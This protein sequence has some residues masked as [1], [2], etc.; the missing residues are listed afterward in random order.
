MILAALPALAA[1]S[2]QDQV[3]LDANGLPQWTIAVWNDF[4]VQLELADRAALEALLAAVPVASFDREQ[5]APLDRDPKSE[6]LVFRPRVTEA[7]FAALEAAGYAPRRLRDFDR[8]GRE[9]AERVWLEMSQNKDEPVLTAPYNYYPTH[10]QVGTI[11]ATIETNFPAI[12]RDFQWGTSI[13]GRALW[14]LVIS[15]NVNSSEAEPEVR[16]S[17]SMHGDEVTGQIMLLNFA[18]YLTENY[19]VPGRE[20]V[21]N[22]VDNYEIH[23]MPMHNPDG[24]VLNQRGNANGVDL[25]RNFPEPAGD[26]LVQ[27]TENLA[28]MSY[29]HSH[30]FVMSSNYHGGALVVNYLWDYTYTLAPDDAACI[31]MSLEYSTYN[32]PMYNGSFPQGITNGA[33]WYVALGTLQDWSYDQTGCI[34]ATI[35]VSN[36]KWPSASLLPTFWNENRES[37]MHYVK[38]ARYGVNGVVTGSDTGQ[39]LDATVTVTGNSKV[40]HTDPSHGDYYKLLA[41]G[42]YQLTFSAYGY[43]TRTISNV[44]T[45]W[46]TPTVLNVALDPIATGAIAGHVMQTGG[47]PVAAQVKA[48]THPLNELIDTVTANAAGDYELTGLV[49]GDYRLVYSATGHTTEEQ[50]VTL[51][52]ASVIA[53]DV[54]LGLTVE[55][56]PF[57]TS[58]ENGLTD[59]W[60][61]EYTWGLLAG[62]PTGSTYEMTDS[63]TT[64]YLNNQIS[65]CTM[66]AGA[67]LTDMNS[68][69]VSFQAKWNIETNWDGVQ[70]Q[71]SV[72]GGSVWTPVATP[73][74]QSGSGQ[75]KQIAG[76]PYFENAQAAWVLNTVDL[77]PWL[78][79]PDVRFRFRLN[80]DS[81]T[82]RDGFHFD[83]FTIHGLGESIN[84]GAG[85][86]PA[87]AT[88]ITAAYPNPFNPS[89]TVAFTLATAGRA[90]LALYDAAGRRVRTL[91]GGEMT[92]GEH[93]AVWDG[94]T[95][96]GSR[97]PSGVYFARLT[98]MG[99]SSVQKLV[100][101]K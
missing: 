89:T 75:G 68:G 2:T 10:A 49:Y 44:S 30:H 31:K 73:Y 8:E 11:F 57:A 98:A 16:L 48:Y 66:T 78:G 101:V 35:E 19:G 86:A 93:V 99:A 25:N 52:A 43:I 69:T 74:T 7:E 4:P 41:T 28:F 17:S 88:A 42:T 63:P 26:D 82:T 56:T 60:T 36:T 54:T 65:H 32:S 38:S 13:Q 20:D 51:D 70:F 62:G 18:H 97:A 3:P 58:F 14:G 40:V 72:D 67:D 81:S 29:A 37:L 96:G 80:T 6:R 76:Q 84:T 53:P 55:L 22:L 34:D 61:R 50:V 23:L 71:V 27:E 12:A 90:E 94:Q 91:A 46:G 47:A 92:A 45:T 15:D 33:D 39:P 1:A 87:R 95:E 79:Q 59:G 21:T 9:A 100:L 5:I 83:D 77:A 64:N 24:T 85:D